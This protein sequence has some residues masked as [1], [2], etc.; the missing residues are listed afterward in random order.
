MSMNRPAGNR[1]T[2]NRV[3]AVVGAL[4]VLWLVVAVIGFIVKALFWLAIVGLVLFAATVL[5][6]SYK[7]RSR[8]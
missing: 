2:R 5:Y 6:G 8:R 3:L 4:L 7:T 1:L